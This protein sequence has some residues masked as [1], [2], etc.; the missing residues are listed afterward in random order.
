MNGNGDGGPFSWENEKQSAKTAFDSLDK[1]NPEINVNKNGSQSDSGYA[2]IS[3]IGKTTPKNSKKNSVPS[4]ENGSFDSFFTFQAS[5]EP[6]P[7]APIEH[8]QDLP[9]F[10]FLTQAVNRPVNPVQNSQPQRRQQPDKARTKKTNTSRKD[11]KTASAARRSSTPRA[12]QS[13][14]RPVQQSVRQQNGADYVQRPVRQAAPQ[15]RQSTKT[16]TSS[17]K[18]KRPKQQKPGLINR[19]RTSRSRKKVERANREY[20]RHTQNGMSA[21]EAKKQLGQKRKRKTMFF[22]AIG[23]SLVMVIAVLSVGMFCY[24]KGFPIE[25]VKIEGETV[26]TQKE[27]Q[28]AGGIQIGENIFRVSTK[29][30]N[31]AITKAL[32]YIYSVKIKRSLPNSITVI[33]EPTVEKYLIT[34]N[35]KYICLDEHN[36]VVSEKKMKVKDGKY[37]LDGFDKQDYVLGETFEPTEMNAKRLEQ[38]KKI[39]AELEK[40]KMGQFNIIS[41]ANLSEIKITNSEK[42]VLVTNEEIDFSVKLSQASAAMKQGVPFSGAYKIDLRFENP[43]LSKE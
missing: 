35:G 14:Q 28:Q 31:E 17:K 3:D 2:F 7:S 19:V 1:Y 42:V 43:V 37:R 41:L 25:S 33:V 16:K 11:K 38:A 22:A 34:V 40:A 29:Q 13:G 12:Q 27:I 9:D 36:K 23:L 10:D 20:I 26:Y 30:A 18:G 6:F 32:P 8:N 21:N 4:K 24:M 5:N 39:I 15:S